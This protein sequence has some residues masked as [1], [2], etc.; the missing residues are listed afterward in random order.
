MKDEDPYLKH[1]VEPLFLF[2]KIKF[3]ENPVE[4]SL[5]DNRFP[6]TLVISSIEAA[7]R[8]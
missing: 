7:P 1:G 6:P 4:K 8:A 3:F 2:K 5:T